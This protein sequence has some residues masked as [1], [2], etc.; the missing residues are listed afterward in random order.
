M[1][2][3]KM[4]LAITL[5]SASVFASAAQQCGGFYLKGHSDGL[6][7]V[8]GVKP[9]SQKVTFLKAKG[10]YDNVMFQWMVEDAKTGQLLGMESVRRDAKS[11]LNVEAVRNNMDAPRVFGTY[12]CEKVK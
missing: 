2:I 4:A 11:I 9:L 7:Y 8:N 1:I 10:D 3:R 5:L 6:V 12:D